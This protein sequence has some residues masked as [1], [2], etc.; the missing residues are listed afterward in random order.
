M[1]QRKD[2]VIP[3]QKKEKKNLKEQIIKTENGG[4]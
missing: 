4:Y 1:F 3:K 2:H